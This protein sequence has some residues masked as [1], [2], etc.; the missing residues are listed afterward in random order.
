MY[1][2]LTLCF[3]LFPRYRSVRMKLLSGLSSATVNALY[4]SKIFEPGSGRRR[5]HSFQLEA[6]SFLCSFKVSNIYS[7]FA[8]IFRCTL[9]LSAQ[10]LRAD[11]A[12]QM[13]RP[14]L[15][16]NGHLGDSRCL[17]GITYNA[18]D[19]F[20]KRSDGSSSG[21]SNKSLLTSSF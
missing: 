18:N 6:T 19:E 17:N 3:L 2:P 1:G 20:R 11:A 12:R 13:R 21:H 4:V 7:K 10:T 8:S 14:N 9:P 16:C 5:A 15:H